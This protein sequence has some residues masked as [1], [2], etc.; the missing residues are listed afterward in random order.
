MKNNKANVFASRLGRNFVTLRLTTDTGLNQLGDAP[1]NARKLFVA[2]YLK[3]RICSQLIGRNAHRI[4]DICQSFC[5]LGLKRQPLPEPD[6]N[7]TRVAANNARTLGSD[8][9]GCYQHNPFLKY[10]RGI[11]RQLS[12]VVPSLYSKRTTNLLQGERNG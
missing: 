10:P 1:L 12:F 2:S 5:Q 3:D 11:G 7:E 4:E 6:E 9:H 8:M